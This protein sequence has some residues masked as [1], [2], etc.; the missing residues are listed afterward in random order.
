VGEAQ[1]QVSKR[2]IEQFAPAK[3]GLGLDPRL[4]SIANSRLLHAKAR[5]RKQPISS[6]RFESN[7]NGRAIVVSV[8]FAMTGFRGPCRT[9]HQLRPQQPHGNPPPLIPDPAAGMPLRQHVRGPPHSPT[10]LDCAA[11]PVALKQS[12]AGSFSVRP[13]QHP[14]RLRPR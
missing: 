9:L 3:N 2:N 1:P 7:S 12:R 6:L 11:S 8:G 4:L 13:Q 14:L 10:P 5:T